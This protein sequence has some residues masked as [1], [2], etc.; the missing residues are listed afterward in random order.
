MN[1]Q[2]VESAPGDLQFEENRVGEPS[3]EFTGDDEL[4]A[5]SSD[6]QARE[7]L[8]PSDEA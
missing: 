7:M 5:S 3:A 1:E 2:S 8:Q 4:G 6:E